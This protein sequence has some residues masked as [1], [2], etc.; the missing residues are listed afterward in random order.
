MKAAKRLVPAPH[1]GAMLSGTAFAL[2]VWAMMRL[3]FKY[4]LA[5]LLGTALLALALFFFDRLGSFLLY[6]LV[7]NVP[8]VGF[9]KALFL[10]Q[11]AVLATAGIGIGLADFIL[12][13]LYL[14]WWFRILERKEP[15]PALQRTDL[16]ALAFLAVNVL[17]WGIT[18]SRVY[19]FFEIVRVAKC[20]LLYFYVSRNLKKA[21]LKWVVLLLFF[22][23]VSQSF[24]GF[25][26]SLTGNLIGLG[27]TKGSIG[28]S[29]TDFLNL[30]PGFGRPQASGTLQ[31]PHCLGTFLDMLLMVALA[32][33]LEGSLRPGYRWLAAAVLLV[34]TAAVI[35]TF[36]RGAWGTLAITFFLVVC[37]YLPRRKMAALAAVAVLLCLVPVIVAYREG[38]YL[39]LFEAPSDIMETRWRLNQLAWEKFKQRPLLGVGANAFYQAHDEYDERNVLS[40]WKLPP[41]HNIP[42]FIAS[43]TGLL[44][45]LTFYGLLLSALS[46]CWS[47]G[48]SYEPFLRALA[49]GVFAGLI[50]EQI[51]GITNFTFYTTAIY[52]WTWLSFGLAVGLS[53][54]F[55]SRPVIAV[56]A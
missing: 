41:A 7:F 6:L 24:L 44:G 48:R 20:L 9:E 42:L 15:W 51:E 54:L 27:A 50:A 33:L 55:P 1:L 29:D 21:H 36:A 3:E 56:A 10:H 8:L 23:I 28:D 45:L 53:N 17:S 46:R 32:L 37:L 19:T 30:V 34:G 38:I 13:G 16:W 5:A 14:M 40:G 2:A 52:Y 22:V 4:A 43:Q 39:R 25:Y 18:A 47:A 12:V 31:T 26:Q 49:I 11:E 35:A